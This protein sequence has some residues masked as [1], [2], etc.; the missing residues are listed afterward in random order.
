MT[1]SNCI[2][3]TGSVCFSISLSFPFFFHG[4]PLADHIF[5]GGFFVGSLFFGIAGV[6]AKSEEQSNEVQS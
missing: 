4:N 6:V 3:A 1:L 5:V 2:A